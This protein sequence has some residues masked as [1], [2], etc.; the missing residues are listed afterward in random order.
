MHNVAVLYDILGAFQPHATGVFCALLAA[1]GDKI[2]I[3]DRLGADEA[4]FEIGM[5]AARSL[6][7]LGSPLNRPGAR[8]LW[9]NGKERDQVEQLVPGSDH[10]CETGLLEPELRQKFALFDGIGELRQLR[11]DRRRDYD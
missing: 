6:R 2:G 10:P 9:A 7:C 8:L 4:L 1:M 5:D 3:A 11:L